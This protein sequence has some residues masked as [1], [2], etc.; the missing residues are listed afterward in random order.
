L[1]M[2]WG[3]WILGSGTFTFCLRAGHD[4]PGVGLKGMYATAVELFLHERDCLTEGAV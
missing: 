3:A 2:C 1:K 4:V